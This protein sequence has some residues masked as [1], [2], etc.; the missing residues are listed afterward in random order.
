M[1]VKVEEKDLLWSTW[2]E[3]R[4]NRSF[5][6]LSVNSLNTSC[7][8]LQERIRWAILLQS[9]HARQNL[10]FTTSIA[11]HTGG[12]AKDQFETSDCSLFWCRYKYLTK[13]VSFNR[14]ICKTNCTKNELEAVATRSV[15]FCVKEKWVFTYSLTLNAAVLRRSWRLRLYSRKVQ[16]LLN[17]ADECTKCHACWL[18][19]GKVARWLR[20]HVNSHRN[21]V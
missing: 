13:E 11:V 7:N 8:L 16:K 9:L 21:S 15:S 5:H 18:W 12:L 2:Y 3:K 14:F 19:G 17:K 6:I 10:K 1:Q 4:F 20:I